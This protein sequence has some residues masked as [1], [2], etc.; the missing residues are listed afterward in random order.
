MSLNQQAKKV[1]IL[2]AEVMDLDNLGQT[3][4]LHNTGIPDHTSKLGVSGKAM[5]SVHVE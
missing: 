5:P 3:V 2:L 1:A 4:L